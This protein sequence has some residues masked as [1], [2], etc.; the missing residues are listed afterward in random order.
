MVMLKGRTL[1][2]SDIFVW[3]PG[4]FM[5][6]SL[7]IHNKNIYREKRKKIGQAHIFFHE[8]G[9]FKYNLRCTI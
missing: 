4:C 2:M 3:H 8:G 1:R 5:L 9:E 6:G 7:D